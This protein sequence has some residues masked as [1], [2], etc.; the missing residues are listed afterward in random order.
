LIKA[1]KALGNTEYALMHFIA[2]LTGA[3]EQTVLTLRA[4]DFMVPPSKIVQWPFKL[5]CGPGTGFDTKRDAAG[6]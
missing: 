4:R 1:L 3:R 2:L 5:R 6:V